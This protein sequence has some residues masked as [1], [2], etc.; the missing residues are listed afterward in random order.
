MNIFIRLYEKK[1]KIGENLEL[2]LSEKEKRE[3]L[4]NEHA[5]RKPIGCGFTIHSGYGCDNMC[6]YC[7]I[8][9]MGLEF[10][11]VKENPLNGKQMLYALASNPYIIPERISLAFGSIS[12]PFHPKLKEKTLEY[13]KELKALGNPIQFSTKFYISEHEAKILRNVDRNMSGLITIVTLKKKKILEPRAPEIEERIETIKILKKYIKPA[14]FLR[15]II[16]GITEDEIE[17]IINLAKSLNVPI[18]FG[19]FRAT[20]NNLKRLEKFFDI[21]EIKR[22]LPV[23]PQGRKQ[24]NLEMNDIILK[25]IRIAQE[26]NVRYFIRAS[27][28]NAWAHKIINPALE[29]LKGGCVLCENDCPNRIPY[30]SKE[31]IEEFLEYLNLKAKI[32]VKPWKVIIKGK[33]PLWVKE[34]IRTIT[35]KEVKVA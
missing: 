13:M 8:Q 19:I 34:W 23:K 27:C 31:E 7:Y 21:S 30:I 29:F 35:Y 32:E 18:V 3:A 2:E 15:P 33:I 20:E 26:Y 4:K 10:T 25:A 24:V 5:R 28:H 14:I 16:P 12:D 1:K 17:D 22:R 6:L 9:D 11:K